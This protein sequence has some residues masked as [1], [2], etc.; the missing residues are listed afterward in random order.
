MG[1][2]VLG[3]IWYC[4][5]LFH[6]RPRILLPSFRS[7]IYF[8]YWKAATRPGAL[9]NPGDLVFC[10]WND[11]KLGF[12]PCEGQLFLFTLFLGLSFGDPVQSPRTLSKPPSHKVGMPQISIFVPYG[13]WVVFSSAYLSTSQARISELADTFSY[14]ML[15]LLGTLDSLSHIPPHPLFLANSYFYPYDLA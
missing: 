11:W 5:C 14:M 4:I 9:T 3:I 2:T 10:G 15:L 12:I 13:Q 7:S 1:H 8:C 6:L